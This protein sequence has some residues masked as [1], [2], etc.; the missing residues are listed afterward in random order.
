MTFERLKKEA[1]RL[2]KLVNTEYSEVY[3][4]KWD[5]FDEKINSAYD[6]GLINEEQFNEL[7]LIAFYDYFDLK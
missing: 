5:K 3:A 4:E 6:N 1:K 7:A 2:E